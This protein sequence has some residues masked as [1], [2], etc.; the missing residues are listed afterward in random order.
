M[1]HS[2]TTGHVAIVRALFEQSFA[3]HMLRMLTHLAIDIELVTPWGN[4][5]DEEYSIMARATMKAL[6]LSMSGASR[7]K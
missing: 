5:R 6:C 2:T 4:L 1:N 3:T 7:L